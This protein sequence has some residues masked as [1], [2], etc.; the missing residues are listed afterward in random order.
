MAE[1]LAALRGVSV[2][3]GGAPLFTEADLT[4]QRRD[5]LCLVGRNGSGKSTVL[6]L[7]AG[8][9]EP[10]SGAC[11]VAS[12]ARVAR[13]AQDVD[14]GGGGTVGDFV[15]GDHLG[16]AAL[17]RLGLDAARAVAELS[18]G[19]ARRAALARALAGAPEL[20][21]LDEPTNHLD[22]AGIEWLERWL[23]DFPGA[24]VLVSHDR[25]LLAKTS[26]RAAWLD[27]GTLR[28]R[29]VGFAGF[30]A[31]RDEVLTEERAAERRGAQHLKAEARWL[32]RG[33]TAR[34]RRNKGRLRALYA[35][36]AERAA[37][38]KDRGRAKLALASVPKGGKVAIEAE[39][40]CKAFD[41]RAVIRDFSL[42]MLRGDRV[43]V[44]GPNG[45]GKTT[46]L[47]LLIG[48]LA[49]DAGT[50]TRA[51]TLEIVY[52]DQRREALDP[53]RTLWE[54]LCPQGGDSLMVRGRQR[55]VV[56]YLRDFLFDEA[57]ARSP[58]CAL[59]G[60][61]GSRLLLARLFAR[62]ADLLVLD[63]PTNDLDTETL[64]LLLEVLGEFDGTVLMVS[65]DRD[66]IDRLATSTVALEGDGR[67]TEYVGGYTDYLRQRE[68]AP[69][70]PRRAK[71]AP[72]KRPARPRPRGPRRALG[73]QQ[74]RELDALPGEM[75]RLSAEIGTLEATLADAGLY[76]RDPDAFNAA[77]A[78]LAAARDSL[79]VAETRW[80]ELEEKREA[81]AAGA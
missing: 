72:A 59:S 64:D 12:G 1:L 52:F 3:F 56:G 15:G 6:K 38:Q 21:L 25:A 42:R 53:D 45:A 74:Q 49:P 32:H 70:K 28:V 77:T 33:V 30:E 11:W 29:D 14:L 65:H 34:R 23:A 7:L 80:V 41:G 27:S 39:G 44:I 54:T 16:R 62:P 67:A 50:A 19:E 35:L 78:R 26:R 43:A 22:I 76:E 61:E 18:G 47:R 79:D 8:E 24:L 68:T 51:E 81:L 55:H 37:A 31:W 69:A 10:D 58:V 5:R 71:S 66:F 40:L 46:L 2:T 60:G 63:E 13:L 73:Y 17:D 48:E 36:R 75:D 4:I 20:L 57:Q 9:M